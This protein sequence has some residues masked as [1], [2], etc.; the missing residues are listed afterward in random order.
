MRQHEMPCRIP[1]VTVDGNEAKPDH[2]YTRKLN[3]GQT[4]PDDQA[5]QQDGADRNE[6]YHQRDMRAP[7]RA[8]R[9]G[10]CNGNRTVR[11]LMRFRIRPPVD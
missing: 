10:G 8:S 6:Q 7:A 5:S 4:R 9:A 2:R 1:G 11:P 3:A